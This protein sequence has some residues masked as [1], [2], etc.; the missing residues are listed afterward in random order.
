MKRLD[1]LICVLILAIA[2]SLLAADAAE[3]YTLSP[4]PDV[5]V[6]TGA[7]LRRGIEAPPARSAGLVASW[8]LNGAGFSHQDP[9]AG[10]IRPDLTTRHCDYTAPDHVPTRN[11][12]AV[13]VTLT[14]NGAKAQI[15]LV[16][17]VTI[18]DA[19]N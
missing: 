6:P 11:P 5:R 17:N 12:V 16:C 18:V 9:A 2:R 7:T 3:D 13:S 8:T 14:P 10:R 1:L 4:G 15:T 19:P